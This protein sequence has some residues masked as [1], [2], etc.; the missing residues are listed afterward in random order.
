MYESSGTLCLQLVQPCVTRGTTSDPYAAV[1]YFLPSYCFC[2][3]DSVPACLYFLCGGGQSQH[4]SYKLSSPIHIWSVRELDRPS[5]Q[6]VE[7]DL[8]QRDMEQVCRPLNNFILLKAGF[9]LRHNRTFCYFII[10]FISCWRGKAEPCVLCL[11]ID[12][13]RVLSA[14][15]SKKSMCSL[16][17]ERLWWPEVASDVIVWDR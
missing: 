3:L 9:V 10:F 2:I 16:T 13:T 15:Y 8:L 12:P 5:Q 14:G 11:L 6:P 4:R 1:L 7:G 17:W